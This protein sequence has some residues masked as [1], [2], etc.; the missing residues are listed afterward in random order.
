MRVRH[1]GRRVAR[2]RCQPRT[3]KGQDR[4]RV[5]RCAVARGPQPEDKEKDPAIAR[6][7]GEASRRASEPVGPAATISGQSARDRVAAHFSSYD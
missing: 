6:L 5:F 4:F 2:K 1:G 7:L 3:R